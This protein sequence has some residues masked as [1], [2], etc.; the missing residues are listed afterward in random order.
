MALKCQ[1]TLNV[2]LARPPLESRYDCSDTRRDPDDVNNV[3]AGAE[4]NDAAG[5][6]M[7]VSYKR[8]RELFDSEKLNVL[9]IQSF[10]NILSARPLHLKI[11]KEL[12]DFFLSDPQ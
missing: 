10:H 7:Y 12:W 1:P 9:N 4:K 2:S 11:G 3:I 5:K 6:E 8:L